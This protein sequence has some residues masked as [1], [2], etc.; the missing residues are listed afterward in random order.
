MIY[1]ITLQPSL[2]YRVSVPQY[3]A[4]QVNLAAGEGLTIGGRGIQISA[5]LRRMGIDS[6][7]LGILSGFTG[8]YIKQ[9][10]Q[11]L[12][13]ET[14]FVTPVDDGEGFSRINI[15]VEGS[16]PTAIAGVGPHITDELLEQLLRRMEDGKMGDFAV[17]A[18]NL[19]GA[20]DTKVYAH[21]LTRLNS[22]QMHTVLDVD[23]CDLRAL[24]TFHPFLVH[25][26]LAGLERVFARPMESL[27]DAM[28]YVCQMQELGA[29]NVLV[30]AGDGGALLTEHEQIYFAQPT[31]LEDMED[32]GARIAG[33]LQGYLQQGNFA[34]AFGGAL[35]MSEEEQKA[36]ELELHQK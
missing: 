24:L 19:P 12:K 31:T 34:D 4:D 5:R 28:P 11:E 20:V 27:E 2:D 8:A 32:N 17:L 33:F 13:C 1:T 26:S 10:L 25:V 7:C 16:A 14:R 35:C 30:R 23:G 22:R 6:I 3:Q 21:I 29:R 9:R 18:D 15:A 36:P